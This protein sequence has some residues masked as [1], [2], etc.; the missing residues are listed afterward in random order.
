[1]NKTL[2]IYKQILDILREKEKMSHYEYQLW[3]II[4]KLNLQN[5]MET[6]INLD[7]HMKLT[8]VKDNDIYKCFD[9]FYNFNNEYALKE[10][11]YMLR[12]NILMNE[13]NY[14]DQQIVQDLLLNI[15]R[16]YLKTYKYE[17]EESLINIQKQYYPQHDFDIPKFDDNPDNISDNEIDDNFEGSED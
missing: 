5:D 7:Q 15:L 14:Q 11:I 4:T 13:N 1:M 6:I 12:D 10:T 2:F 16:N 17:M 9:E 8:Y 3:M